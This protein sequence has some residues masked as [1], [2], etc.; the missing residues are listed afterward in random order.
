MASA[1][2]TRRKPLRPDFRS[3]HIE[4]ERSPARLV[5]GFAVRFHSTGSMP[6]VERRP[7]E[8]TT[9]HERDSVIQSGR[10]Q[11]GAERKSATTQGVFVARR[12]V[13]SLP[14]VT[15]TGVSGWRGDNVSGTC[16]RTTNQS[17][18]EE[19]VRDI[20]YS[21]SGARKPEGM[22]VSSPSESDCGI[23]AWGLASSMR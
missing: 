4:Q 11:S 10:N 18:I 2:A 23:W 5:Q 8:L 17:S 15:I 7:V 21:R 12:C 14:A 6:N 20:A 13:E 19:R 1:S 3:P 16:F 22:G 9:S